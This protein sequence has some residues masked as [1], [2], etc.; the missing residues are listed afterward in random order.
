MK[1]TFT[2]FLEVD[3]GGQLPESV[4]AELVAEINKVLTTSPYTGPVLIQIY[5]AITRP[6]TRPD[7]LKHRR[8]DAGQ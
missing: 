5:G 1:Q 3:E 7:N 8:K 6:T 4:G 2:L